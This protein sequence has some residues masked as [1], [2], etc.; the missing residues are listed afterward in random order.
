VE[1]LV[2][3]LA[4]AAIALGERLPGLRFQRSRFRRRH[5][6]TDGVY[7]AS[8]ALGL[9]ALLRE[10]GARAVEAL[11]AVAPDLAAL[12]L[13][14][15]LLLATL[16]YD[17]GAYASHLLL[18]R[19]EPLWRLHKVHH[20]SP[21]LDWLATFRGHILEHA[22]R[23]L[24]STGTLLALGLPLRAVAGAAAVY[25]AWAAFGHANLR[26]DLRFLEPLLITPRLHRLH[27]VPATSERNLGTIFSL[28]DRLRGNLVTEGGVAAARMGVPGEIDSYP[29]SWLPQLLQPFRRQQPS[30]R[31]AGPPMTRDRGGEP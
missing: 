3:P 26:I 2:L 4:L 10:G 29:Q 5:F 18:H 7:L 20:S 21:T 25:A 1:S 23:H 13:P 16:L 22:L 19:V 9:G 27:H 24:A 8:G 14:V 6:G 30:S 12:P 11:G 17:L 31:S 15:A 28:W